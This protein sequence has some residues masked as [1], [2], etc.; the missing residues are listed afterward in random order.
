MEQHSNSVEL[1]L[2]SRSI[3]GFP[4]GQVVE[5]LPACAGA[6]GSIPGWGTKIPHASGCISGC[7]Q[8]LF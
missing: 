7:S 8:K 6:V 5:T 2:K 1:L 4:G 3:G